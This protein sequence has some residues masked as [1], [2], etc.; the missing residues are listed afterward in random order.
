MVNFL[1][2]TFVLSLAF[3]V[4][5]FTMVNG[6]GVQVQSWGWVVFGWVGSVFLTAL[7]KLVGDSK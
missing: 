7:S 3:M 2:S 5:Y 4:G 1:V 6:W